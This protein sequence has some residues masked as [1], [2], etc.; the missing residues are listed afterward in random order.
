MAKKQQRSRSKRLK[1]YKLCSRTKF[2]RVVASAHGA[3]SASR[4]MMLTV[5]EFADM[6]KIHVVLFVVIFC[7]IYCLLSP[8]QLGR[9]CRSSG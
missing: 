2:A 4:L 7:S 6:T 1:R 8:P 3:N 5:A 9:P